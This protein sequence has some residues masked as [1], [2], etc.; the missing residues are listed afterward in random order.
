[1]REKLIKVVELNDQEWGRLEELL[2]TKRELF[3]GKLVLLPEKWRGKGE[4]LDR[5]GVSY[6]KGG[7]ECL[8][9]TPP[10]EIKEVK[11]EVERERGVKVVEKVVRS[12]QTI[13]TD[14]HLILKNRVNA[15]ARIVATGG[16]VALEEFEGEL[17]GEGP[18]L[19]VLKNYGTIIYKGEELEP[20]RGEQVVLVER[21][22]NE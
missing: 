22:G 16:V 11:V 20:G 4:I 1:M 15:G 8:K 9:P 19:I 12:G 10:A 5:F 2:S 7:R 6:L 18:F 13:Q 3:E 17:I 21:S 14:S